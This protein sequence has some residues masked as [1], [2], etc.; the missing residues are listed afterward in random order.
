MDGDRRG[1]R[2]DCSRSS[3]YENVGGGGENGKEFVPLLPS[4]SHAHVASI[5]DQLFHSGLR[6]TFCLILP[7]L[8]NVHF[9]GSIFIVKKGWPARSALRRARTTVT[10]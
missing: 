2:E 3:K 4:L 7:I 8:W 9:G 6:P 10:C 1:E 5:P